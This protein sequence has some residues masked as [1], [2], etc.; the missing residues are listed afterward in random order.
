MGVL[1]STSRAVESVDFVGKTVASLDAGCCN[2][3]KFT[4]T[5]GT[6][7]EIWAEVDEYGLP[8]IEVDPDAKS[9]VE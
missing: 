5:D 2:V 1:H 9:G 6:Y 4:F 8:C 7:L 3:V